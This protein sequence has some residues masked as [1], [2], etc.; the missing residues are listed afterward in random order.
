MIFAEHMILVVPL[1]KYALKV[2][3]D[4]I[5]C[6]WVAE[7]QYAAA[8]GPWSGPSVRSISGSEFQCCQQFG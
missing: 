2:W 6:I 3:S 1:T 5:W 8:K 4:T 7:A